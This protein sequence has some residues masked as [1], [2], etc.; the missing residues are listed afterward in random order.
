MESPVISHP[1]LTGSAPAD[2]RG[3]LRALWRL[4]WPL[5]AANLL[6]MAVYAS[7]VIFV[8]RLGT[9]ALAAATLGVYYYTVLMFALIGR[10]D[11]RAL[12]ALGIRIGRETVYLP[13]L[14]KPAQAAMRGFLWALADG[15]PPAAPR[16]AGSP[17]AVEHSRPG[18]SRIH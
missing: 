18:H 12:R 7:D 14:V 13:A 6:Q 11:R 3:E 16:A 9:E 17:A 4:A 15:R 8:A 1:P 2:W 5:V 10:D